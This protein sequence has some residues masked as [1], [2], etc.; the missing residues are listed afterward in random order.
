VG[1]FVVAVAVLLPKTVSPA[2]ADAFAVLTIGPV[3]VSERVP[4]AVYVTLPPAS[5]TNVSLMVP[6]PEAVFP[7]AFVADEVN[8]A[9]VKA[10][11]KASVSVVV[12]W[13]SPTF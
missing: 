3:A 6:V 2:A 8:A 9:P 5:I 7:V 12:P 11:G 4:V 1:R 10:V 13:A